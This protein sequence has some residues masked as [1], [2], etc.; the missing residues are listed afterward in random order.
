MSKTYQLYLNAKDSDAIEFGQKKFIKGKH[1]KVGDFLLKKIMTT[2]AKDKRRRERMKSRGQGMNLVDA[3]QE[4]ITLQVVG[5]GMMPA[6][7]TTE[8]LVNIVGDGIVE[9]PALGLPAE[10]PQGNDS[11]QQGEIHLENLLISL[12]AKE[13]G[14]VN[15]ATKKGIGPPGEILA[16]QNKESV[17]RKSMQTLLPKQWLINKVIHFFMKHCLTKCD[18]KLCKKEPGRNNCTSST[19]SLCK[20]C[21]I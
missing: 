3:L 18:K 11:L 8:N 4:R 6:L 12:T 15:R 16:S 9:G 1:G 13:Q 10:I 7:P 21:S 2:H 17:S 14:V 5:D 20:R 19:H